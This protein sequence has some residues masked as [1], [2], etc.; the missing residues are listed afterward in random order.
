MQSY[1][2]VYIYIHTYIHTYIRSVGGSALRASNASSWLNG[3]LDASRNR[4]Q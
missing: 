4:V 1:L 2:R 3:A